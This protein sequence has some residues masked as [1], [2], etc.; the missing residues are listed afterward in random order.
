MQVDRVIVRRRG[1]TIAIGPIGSLVL[2]AGAIAVAD[3][4]HLHP[5]CG[6]QFLAWRVQCE[7]ERVRQEQERHAQRWREQKQRQRQRART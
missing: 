7:R 4:V 6:Q 1:E 2:M 3:E 5:R